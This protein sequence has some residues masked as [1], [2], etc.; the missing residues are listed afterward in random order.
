VSMQQRYIH[1]IRICSL[2]PT[3]LNVLGC[4]STYFNIG[5]LREL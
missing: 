4:E 5:D 3:I 1:L 2:H